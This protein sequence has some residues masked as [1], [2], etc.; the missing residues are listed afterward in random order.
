MSTYLNRPI[1]TRLSMFLAGLPV[2]PDVVSVV[3]L[4]ASLGAALLVAAGLGVAGGIAVQA[5]SILDGVDGEL[6]RLQLRSSPRGA[7]LDGALD[8]LADAAIIG[9]FAIWAA[10]LAPAR[11]VILVGFLALTGAMLS[12]ASKDRARLLGL[13]AAPERLI[14]WM[15]GGRDGRLVL[16]AIA[17]VAGRPV[18]G[19]AAVAV[20]SLVG[21][22]IRLSYVLRDPAAPV[23]STRT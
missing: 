3:V 6:A 8:R 10:S 5:V 19:L 1:S 21:L 4:L 13:R 11:T 12:M 9:G 14:G 2:S 17:A 16:L 18:A 7:M 20:T 23:A 22:G 15:L